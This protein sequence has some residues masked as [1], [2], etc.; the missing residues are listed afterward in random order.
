VLVEMHYR[1]D[2]VAAA[3]RQSLAMGAQETASAFARVGVAGGDALR[4]LQAAFPDIAAA[5]LATYLQAAG[6]ARDTLNDVLRSLHL[7][8]I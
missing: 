3:A 1:V 4:G 2:D 7:P 6:Y 8:T 5:T